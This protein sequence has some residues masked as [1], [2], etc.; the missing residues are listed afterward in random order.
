MLAGGFHSFGWGVHRLPISVNCQYPLWCLRPFFSHITKNVCRT[1]AASVLLFDRNC[2]I[3]FT[4]LPLLIS[5]RGEPVR[6]LL[7]WRCDSLVQLVPSEG[8]CV[9]RRQCVRSVHR[10]CTLATDDWTFRHPASV[11][12]PWT[13]VDMVKASGRSLDHIAAAA[14]ELPSRRAAEP[15]IALRS[16]CAVTAVELLMSSWC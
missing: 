14:L 13:D 16:Q 10:P 9:V 1:P 7:R 12:D 15:L 2:P 11:F 5:G 4:N 8:L 6:I 3:Q